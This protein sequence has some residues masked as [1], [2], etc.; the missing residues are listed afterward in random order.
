M[1]RNSTAPMSFR[2]SISASVTPATSAG[3]AS[4]SATDQ[5][6]PQAVRP[7]VRLTSNAHTD[8]CRKLARA[9][10]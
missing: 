9:V 6:L 2:V 8:C 4:G 5:K 7:R 10:R 1:P 3:R